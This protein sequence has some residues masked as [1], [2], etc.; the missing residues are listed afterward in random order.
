[1]PRDAARSRSPNPRHQHCAANPDWRKCRRRSP[2]DNHSKSSG[3]LS[4]KRWAS[5]SSSS[6][7]TARIWKSS[8]GKSTRKVSYSGRNFRQGAHQDN[9]KS[10]R[11]TVSG[12]PAGAR[13]ACVAY[14]CHFSLS[15]AWLGGA[16]RARGDG[17]RAPPQ[18]RLYAQRSD[19][20]C[21]RR[22][23]LV[24]SSIGPIAPPACTE[25]IARSIPVL[26]PTSTT[27]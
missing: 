17:H 4:R 14:C 9:Q 12:S 1:M 2:N 8:A 6:T 26:A 3:C 11:A 20:Q 16:T 18:H 24:G 5:A 25:S 22:L 10:T 19:H 23:A 7:L 21:G 15:G 27:P 13:Y